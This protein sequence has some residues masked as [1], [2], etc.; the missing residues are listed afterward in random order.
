MDLIQARHSWYHKEV[1]KLA[2]QEALESENSWGRIATAVTFAY[3]KTSKSFY[4]GS[5]LGVLR[6]FSLVE[7]MSSLESIDR[8]IDDD[9]NDGL[10]NHDVFLKVS[11]GLGQR[12]Y[13]SALL[14][15]F[16]NPVAYLFSVVPEMTPILPNLGVQFC[17]HVRAHEERILT[18]QFTTHGV[19][20][21]S[22]D[23]MVK[24]WSFEGFPIGELLQNIPVG[25]KS[26]S[27][28][29]EL[30]VVGIME[31]EDAELQEILERVKELATSS[32]NPDIKVM[33]FSGLEPGADSAEFSRSQLRQRKLGF[34]FDTSNRLFTT[35]VIS[36]LGIEKTSSILGINFPVEVSNKIDFSDDASTISGISSKYSQQSFNN[37]KSAGPMVCRTFLL[38]SLNVI[39]GSAPLI[40]P[41]S[42]TGQK[43][44]HGSTT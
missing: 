41:Q 9:D 3:D 39:K 25:V 21:S 42:I 29:L 35:L 18:I 24:M 6:K 36:L 33:D 22:A 31:K 37:N 23:R 30:D 14:P 4:T 27:W 2:V 40:I 38:L 19:L 15:I 44:S 34:F 16:D 13:T 11:E 26:Q 5:D 28:H 17:W 12:D 7:L 32:D 8:M 10:T 1:M 43:R 20:S